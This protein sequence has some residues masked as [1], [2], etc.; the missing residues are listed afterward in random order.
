ME[1]SLDFLPGDSNSELFFLDSASTDILKMQMLFLSGYSSKMLFKV[2]QCL[3]LSRIIFWNI[4]AQ[5]WG[6]VW[7]ELKCISRVGRQNVPSSEF[8]LVT[9]CLGDQG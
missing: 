8:D 2:L 3:S 1:V 5:V 4:P 9:S 6:L 7:S